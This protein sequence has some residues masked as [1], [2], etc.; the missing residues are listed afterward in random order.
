MKFLKDVL[1]NLLWILRGVIPITLLVMGS[2]QLFRLLFYIAEVGHP[3]ISAI[4][5]LSV[6]LV[7][8]AV[9]ITIDENTQ[10][11]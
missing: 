1:K 3:V 2:I 7:I 8:A 6:L 11:D 9:M 10:S 4:C 5:F